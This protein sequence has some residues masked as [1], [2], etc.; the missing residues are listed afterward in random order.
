MD[1]DKNLSQNYCYFFSSPI[2]TL[3]LN[4]MRLVKNFEFLR[5]FKFQSSMLKFFDIILYRRISFFASLC[6]F[7]QLITVVIDGS[8]IYIVEY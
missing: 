5:I 2:S 1:N 7:K 6:R 4:N 8:Y 3:I